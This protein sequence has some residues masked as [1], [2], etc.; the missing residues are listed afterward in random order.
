VSANQGHVD[1]GVCPAEI[2]T[3]ADEK[4]PGNVI[5]TVEIKM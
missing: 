4:G 5:G 1:V 2:D 3:L